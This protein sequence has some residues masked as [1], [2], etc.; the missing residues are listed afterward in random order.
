M[1]E[2]SST[3]GPAGRRCARCGRELD[4][5]PAEVGGLGWSDARRVA[6]QG[7]IS[8]GSRRNAAAVCTSCLT[9]EEAT[10]IFPA[11]TRARASAG[12]R[13]SRVPAAPAASGAH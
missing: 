9:H 7:W 1:S 6:A 5:S 4:A 3:T 2:N 13:F 8:C 11:R 12:G 10:F